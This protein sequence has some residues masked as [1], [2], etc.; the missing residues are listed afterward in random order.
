MTAVQVPLAPDEIREAAIKLRNDIT[1]ALMWFQKET[2]YDPSVTISW[3]DVT[4]FDSARQMLTPRVSV[5][6]KVNV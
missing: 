3:S 6:V 5:S 2:G 1:N 4:Q